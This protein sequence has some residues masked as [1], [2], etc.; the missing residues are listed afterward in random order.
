[1][2]RPGL[3]LVEVVVALSIAATAALL[4]HAVLGAVS[5]ASVTVISN[6]DRRDAR[7]NGERELRRLMGSA[8]RIAPSR[9]MRGD[10]SAVTW[11]TWCRAPGGWLERCIARLAIRRGP[12]SEQLVLRLPVD[13][14]RLVADSLRSPRLLYLV[15]GAHGGIWRSTWTE[16][17]A[18]P[19]AVAVRS[20]DGLMLFRTGA[21][22]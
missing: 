1:M 8:E 12:G 19:I 22:D 7:A 17:H 2:N 14:E 20:A 5:S 4:A 6:A 10:S 21:R 13:D 11:S 16:R 18:L 15:D 3:T 9:P